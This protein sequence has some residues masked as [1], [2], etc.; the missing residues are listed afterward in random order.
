MTIPVEEL[1][2]LDDDDDREEELLELDDSEDE[3]ELLDELDDDPAAHTTVFLR[4]SFPADV[5]AD[6]V[7]APK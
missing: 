6:A 7:K 1:L 2:E 5:I 4:R 3:D